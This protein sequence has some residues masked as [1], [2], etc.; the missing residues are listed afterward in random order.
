MKKRLSLY[1]RILKKEQE[2]FEASGYLYTKCEERTSSHSLIYIPPAAAYGSKCEERASSHSLIYI[3]P[4]AADGSK[5]EER[6][7]ESQCNDPENIYR[8]TAAYVMAPVMYCFVTWVL[9]N[10]ISAGHRRLYFLARDGYPMY[11]MAKVICEQKSLPLECRY[12]YCSRYALRTAQYHLLGEES[13][14]YICLGGID[15]TFEKIMRRGGLAGDEIKEIA[16]LTGYMDSEDARDIGKTLTYQEIKVLREKLGSCEEFLKRVEG[17]S[18]ENYPRVMGYLEQEGLMDTVSFALV[19]SGW[20]GSMQKSLK[21]LLAGRGSYSQIEGYY[22]GLYEYPAGTD[23]DTYHTYY[24]DPSGGLRRKVYFS[25][26]LFECIYSS[27]EGMTCGYRKREGKYVPVLEKQENPNR[28]YIDK[29][30][31]MLC[32]YTRYMAGHQGVLSSGRIVT[33]QKLLYHF[34]GHPVKE[35]AQVFGSY[36]FCDDVT[37]EKE[38]TVAAPL[39][40][41]D[42]RDNRLLR[43]GLRILRKEAVRESAWLEGSIVLI[44]NIPWL[45]L[46]HGAIYKYVLY[47]RKW[48]NENNRIRQSI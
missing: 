45:A 42:I 3:P 11:H 2:L 48:L 13:L 24:F 25:N 15:V 7:D 9:Q 43:K 34:M 46:C 4:A 6:S 36:V 19:D 1:R 31:E 39:S 18:R 23:K 35:E 44:N 37:G 26:S 33:I 27:N 41:Q 8:I 10:A 16:R 28:P 22:F 14:A 20:T 30:T 5:C 17:H 32:D 21:Q 29:T 12:L 40:C 47:L 38:Q